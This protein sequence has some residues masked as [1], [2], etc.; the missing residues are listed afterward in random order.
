MGRLQACA[1]IVATSLT[2]SVTLSQ[3]VDRHSYSI[4]RYALENASVYVPTATW[5]FDPGG[6]SQLPDPGFEAHVRVVLHWS[7]P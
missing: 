2:K 7:I 5:R 6:P 3:F 4:A 1:K